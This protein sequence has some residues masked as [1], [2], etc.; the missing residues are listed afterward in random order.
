MPRWAGSGG[1]LVAAIGLCRSRQ[2]T[3]AP[4]MATRGRSLVVADNPMVRF[5]FTATGFVLIAWAT[6]L[7]IWAGYEIS[8]IFTDYYGAAER[9]TIGILLSVIV[10]MAAT[11]GI[12]GRALMH[13]G[14]PRRSTSR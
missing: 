14:R 1:W 13:R 2:A 9:A 6:G 8:L 7:F 4:K 3:A 5:I 12:G 11:M 10:M